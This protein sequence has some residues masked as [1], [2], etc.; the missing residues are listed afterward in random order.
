MND[1]KNEAPALSPE[2]QK[3]ADVRERRAKLEKERAELS[4]R[5]AAAEAL[6]IEERKLAEDEA[7]AK[8]QDDFGEDAVAR[9]ATRLGAVIVKKPADILYRNWTETAPK[10]GGY[11]FNHL[12]KLVFPCLVYPTAAMFDHICKEQPATMGTCADEVCAL[13][14]IGFEERLAK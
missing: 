11:T 12:H 9:I 7:F 8:A 2:A 6:V 4:A 10:K 3:L 13:A 1:K 14:G 5:K